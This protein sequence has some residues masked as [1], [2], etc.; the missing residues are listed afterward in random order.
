MR[1][2]LHETRHAQ[3]ISAGSMQAASRVQMTGE[4]EVR[5]MALRMVAT[6]ERADEMR[7]VHHSDVERGWGIAGA[8]VVIAAY[9]SHR[10]TGMPLTPRGQ[11]SQN[12][13]RARLCC[14]KEIA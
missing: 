3:A 2:F 8:A 10:N 12:L 9:Q 7:L 11:Q 1:A 4:H 6:R 5:R 14:V 13:Q